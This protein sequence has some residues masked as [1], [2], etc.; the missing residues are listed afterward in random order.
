M[1]RGVFVLLLRQTAMILAEKKSGTIHSRAVGR[2]D[3]RFGWD[4]VERGEIHYLNFSSNVDMC[5]QRC[6]S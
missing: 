4:Q 6:Y 1:I 3:D 5:N 2:G